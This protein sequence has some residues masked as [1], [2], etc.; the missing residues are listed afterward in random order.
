MD[1]VGLGKNDLPVLEKTAQSRPALLPDISLTALQTRRIIYD[2]KQ[3]IQA[4]VQSHVSTC[5]RAHKEQDVASLPPSG[6]DVLGLLLKVVWRGHD[7]AEDPDLLG[8]GL[9]SLSLA[10]VRPLLWRVGGH[11]SD[12][13]VTVLS[14]HLVVVVGVAVTLMVML[15]DWRSVRDIR[16]CLM[17]SLAIDDRVR[18]RSIVSYHS[19][20]KSNH[21]FGE[22]FTEY[23]FLEL[24]H[25]PLVLVLD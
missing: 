11:L 24:K 19:S 17:E 4:R 20:E 6:L 18:Q 2:C 23:L 13:L 15:N 12:D 8:H 10:F 5:F 16:R 25:S 7:P 1:H 9:G 22:Y 3:R 21:V 14:L